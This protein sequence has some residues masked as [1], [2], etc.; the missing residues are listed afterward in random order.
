MIVEIASPSTAAQDDGRK[1][2]IYEK[3]GVNE[4]WF[5]VDHH[6]VYVYLLLASL[7]EP[8]TLFPLLLLADQFP[9]PAEP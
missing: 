4:Y 1:K 2:E 3:I 9:C 8:F 7:R 5:V 6:N